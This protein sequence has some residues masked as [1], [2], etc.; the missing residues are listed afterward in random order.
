VTLTLV[1]PTVVLV[2]V[3]VVAFALGQDQ[4]P[5]VKPIIVSVMRPL[6][7]ASQKTTVFC[8]SQKPLITVHHQ[9][10]AE[11]QWF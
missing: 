5:R 6:T 3:L 8:G 4:K 9:Y 7:A 1:A 11:Y 2:V 10:L